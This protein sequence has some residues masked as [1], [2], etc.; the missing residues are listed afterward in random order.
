MSLLL[1]AEGDFLCNCPL[2]EASN[3]EDFQRSLVIG[4]VRR[5]AFCGRYHHSRAKTYIDVA[6]DL[7]GNQRFAHGGPGD[8]KSLGQLLFGGETDF[9][10]KILRLRSA[11]EPDQ[12][13]AK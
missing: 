6:F 8:A 5:A 2:N 9:L 11:S 1:H 7:Q 3:P 12:R 13:F 4:T 10:A